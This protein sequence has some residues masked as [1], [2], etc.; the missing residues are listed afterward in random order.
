V[1]ARGEV[2]NKYLNI[3]IRPHRCQSCGKC[4]SRICS[5]RRHELIHSAEE[6]YHCELCGSSFKKPYCCD[7]CPKSFSFLSSYK[8]HLLSHSGEKPYQCD[9]CGKSF[10]Q[11][12]HFSLHLRNHTGEKPYECEQCDKS[13]SDLSSYKIHLR[14]HTGEKPYCCDQCGRSFSQLGNYKFCF[15]TKEITVYYRTYVNHV[16]ALLH[17][18]PTLSSP[19][20]S[21]R[22]MYSYL[23]APSVDSVHK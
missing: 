20:T 15:D 11:S 17:R 18:S 13:F 1:A 6:L 9:F 22:I 2:L 19:F 3:A 12:G 23:I 16:S 4:F 8:R 14:V 10:T 21:V 7:Q 5:L